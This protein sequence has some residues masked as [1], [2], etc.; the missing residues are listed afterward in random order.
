MRTRFISLAWICLLAMTAPSMAQTKIAVANPI[1]ILNELAE[2]KE[3]N[4]SM[5]TEQGSYKQQAVVRE[6]KL[7]EVQAQRDALKS[8]SPQYLELNK[9]LVTL[10]TEA[11]A[12]QQQTQLEL[13]RKFRDQARRMNDKISAAISEIAKAEGYD[14]VLADQKPELTDAQIEQMTP[15]QLLNV[16]FGRNLL[17]RNDT[18]DITQKVIAKLDAAYSAK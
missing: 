9:Q 1:R 14:L 15:P 10:R 5:E 8:D 18:T 12:W 3:I 13:A 6:Q 4:Q 16:L 2:T 17:Y 7:K 11:Q